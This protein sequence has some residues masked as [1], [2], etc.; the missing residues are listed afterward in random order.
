MRKRRSNT[1]NLRESSNR[2]I[3]TSGNS[4]CSRYDAGITTFDTADVYSS[5]N[6]EVILGKA[7]KVHNIPRE[8]VVIMTKVEWARAIMSDIVLTLVIRFMG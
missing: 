7:L 2:R 5:G 8:D 6:S 3:F 1:S 4:R